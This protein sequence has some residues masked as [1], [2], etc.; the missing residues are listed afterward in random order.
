M[1]VFD[2]SHLFT[3]NSY[4]NKK[5]ILHLVMYQEKKKEKKQPRIYFCVPQITMSL[6]Q[7]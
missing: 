5:K 3:Y 2:A 1:N 4:N 6:C 7:M